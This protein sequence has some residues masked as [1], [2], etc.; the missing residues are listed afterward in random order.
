MLGLD[1]IYMGNEGKF[2]LVCAPADASNALEVLRGGAFTHDACLIGRVEPGRGVVMN[3]RIG[4]R[5]NIGPLIGEG[6]PRIC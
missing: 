6:L 2:V 3:T 4:G 1:P 5:R